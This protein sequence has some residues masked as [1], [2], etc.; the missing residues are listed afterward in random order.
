MQPEPAQAASRRRDVRSRFG[1]PAIAALSLVLGTCSRMPGAFEQIRLQGVVKIVTRNSPLAYYE[2]AAGPEGPEYEL[3]SGFARRLGVRLEIVLA[4]TGAAALDA[5]RRNRAQIAAAGIVANAARREQALFGPVFQR[6]DQHVVYR[7]SDPLPRSAADLIDRRIVVIR[8]T[9]HAAALQR[10]AQEWPALRWTEVEGKVPL[11]LLA[12]V[13]N[14]EA[15]VTVADSTEFSLGR[16]FHPELRPAF[17][18]AESEA[19]AWALAPRS[20][21]LLPQVELYFEELEAIGKL[22]EILERHRRSLVRFDRVDAA[23]FVAGVRERLPRYRPWFEEA[24]AETGIDWRLIAAIGYQESRWDESARSPTGVRGL[25]MLTAETAQRVGVR[26]RNDPRDSIL[27]GARYL[28]LIRKTIPARIEEPD[29][30]WLALAAYNVG[31]GHLE[32]ARILAQ[33]RGKSPDAWAD[34]QETLPLLA[35]ER[36]YTRTRRGYAR[37]WEPVGFVRNVQT[38]AELLRWMPADEAASTAG[39]EEPL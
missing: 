20:T 18:L 33:R 19:I 17:K 6:I 2:G 7:V 32:D 12:M 37:G 29:R 15:D 25:M 22:T 14:G 4:P 30:T 23:N 24:A 13:A 36:W 10:L 39:S 3:A 31:Y 1:V 16:H 26:D 21:D 27:G 28:R 35:Q 11:D 5:V 38:Y 34:V 9:T 8:D